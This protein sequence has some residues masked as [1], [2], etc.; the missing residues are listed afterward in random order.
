MEEAT[1]EAAPVLDEKLV[2][3][4]VT[5]KGKEAKEDNCT[6]PQGHCFGSDGGTGIKAKDKVPKKQGGDFKA[7]TLS[8]D[9]QTVQDTN[10]YS[11]CQ[12][13]GK[14]FFDETEAE[15][16]AKEERRY[17]CVWPD[18]TIIDVRTNQPYEIKK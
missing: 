9:K 2:D 17:Q 4:D 10:Y 8:V 6:A 14:Y 11:K 16:L 12:Y 18:G 7:V 15:K 13:C 1:L 5:V 3:F